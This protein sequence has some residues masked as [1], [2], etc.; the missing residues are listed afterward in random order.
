MATRKR[1]PQ[2]DPAVIELLEGLLADARRGEVREVMVVWTD[3]DR[4]AWWRYYAHDAD[5]LIFEGR[6]ATSEMRTRLPA[7]KRTQ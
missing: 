7:K 3:P 1:P 6:V 4:E 5:N 2:G